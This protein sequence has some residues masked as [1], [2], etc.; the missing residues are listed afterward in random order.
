MTAKFESC[1][2]RA[3]CDA[4]HVGR[5]MYEVI[6]LATTF[7]NESREVFVRRNVFTNLPPQT[8]K[9]SAKGDKILNYDESSTKLHSSESKL[10]YGTDPVKLMP[11]KW[12]DYRKNAKKVSS[13][14]TNEKCFPLF[15]CT[16]VS[17]NTGPSAG[18]KF[19]TP[20]GTPAS[21]ITLKI[22]QLES[23]AVSEG[24]HKTP[25]PYS[26]QKFK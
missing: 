21:R 13:S 19:T 26:H 10:T 18:I 3:G 6:V 23:I 9:R 20:G 2:D 12:G 25:F 1:S 7:A 11:A 22:I 16:I 8:I 17:P 24:F 15:T 14:H 5:W 4:L